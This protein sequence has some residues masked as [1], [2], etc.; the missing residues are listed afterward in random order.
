MAQE[1]GDS[2]AQRDEVRRLGER[3][4]IANKHTV[5]LEADLNNARQKLVQSEDEKRALQSSLDKSIA[6]GAR[7]SRRLAEAEGSLNE[8]QG[9]LRH[10]E[11]NFAEINTERERLAATLDELKERHNSE[12]ATQQMRFEALQTR[13]AATEKLL[14]EARD[15]MTA[16]AEEARVFDRRIGEAT[17]ERDALAARLNLIEADRDQREIERRENE[18]ARATLLERGSALAKVYNTKESALARAEE[19]IKSLNEQIGSLETQ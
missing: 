14:L 10:V 7:L 8:T 16:Q 4:V 6:D 19:T 1:T 9:R 5:Q 17:H 18:Q 15:Q 13:A 3:L 2:K 11:A 12:L